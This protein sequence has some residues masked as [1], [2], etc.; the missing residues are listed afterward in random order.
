ML[1]IDVEFIFKIFKNFHF[2]F[3]LK[4]I[5]P[6]IPHV[7]EF[8]RHILE[9]VGPRLSKKQNKSPMYGFSRT[10]SSTLVSPKINLIGVGSHRHVRKS[11]N[12]KI[13]EIMSFPNFSK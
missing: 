1:L 7:R 2:M 5:D 10:M 6:I 8:V 4:D 3:F 9:I 13:V 11:E 12:P